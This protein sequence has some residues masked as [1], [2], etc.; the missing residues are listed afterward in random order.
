MGQGIKLP[1]LCHLKHMVKII[2][3]QGVHILICIIQ[4]IKVFL[5]RQIMY[6]SQHKIE[7]DGGQGLPGRF[8][9]GDG[10]AQLDALAYT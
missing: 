9:I 3:E 7:G 4:I 5:A 6:R 8:R 10:L 1:P 2:A